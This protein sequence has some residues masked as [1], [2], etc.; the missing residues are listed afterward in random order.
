MGSI[1]GSICRRGMANLT[2]P[3]IAKLRW[4]NSKRTKAGN[5]PKFQWHDD[6]AVAGHHIRLY[7]PKANGQSN[8]VF[9][10]KYGPDVDRKVYR[11]GTWGEWTLEASRAEARRIR[12][13]YYDH[14]VDPNEAKQKRLQKAKARLTVKELMAEYFEAHKSEW[15]PKYTKDSGTY[16]RYLEKAFGSRF[17]EGITTDDIKALFLKIKAHAPSVAD[18][19]Q[20]FTLRMYS[21]AIDEKLVPKMD[22]PAVIV[23][24]RS[25]TKSQYR[26][27]KTVRKR[28]LE[29]KKG[30]ATQLFKMLKGYDPIYLSIAKLYLLTGVRN[31]ELRETGWEDIDTEQR[32]LNNHSPKGGRKNG[33]QVPLCD[34][35]MDILKDLGLNKIAKGPIFPAKTTD[36]NGNVRPCR[37]WDEWTRTIS[38]D[39][40]M[41][42]CPDEGHI[43]IH[44]LRRTAVTWLQEM[45]V[46][47]ENRT[48]FKGSRPSGVTSATY[49]HADQEYIRRQC[50]ELIEERLHD[51]EA[52]KEKTMFKPWR[53]RLHTTGLGS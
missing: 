24:S 18:A 41:P 52:G 49:S 6:P 28:V 11:I 20:G 38:K 13:A 27:P 43:Q 45:R 17:A 4:D 30:E 8:K 16:R 50:V 9:Y 3:K 53:G 19:L 22:N 48:L 40:R 36:S 51:I 29:S 10:L 7:P 34:M 23:R 1:L 21:W 42:V 12:R 32:T 46:S 14:Q 26:I 37:D 15:S 5:V 44:D 31:K 25:R 39:P 47:V 2:E 35:A 33:Y